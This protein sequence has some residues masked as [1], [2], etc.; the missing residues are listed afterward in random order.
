MSAQNTLLLPRFPLAACWKPTNGELMK[1]MV[2]ARFV[3]DHEDDYKL[4][5]HL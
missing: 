4:W 3:I 1:V 2:Q 5:E